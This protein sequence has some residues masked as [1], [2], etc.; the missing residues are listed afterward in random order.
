MPKVIAHIDLNAFFVR[1]EEIRNPRLENKPVAVGGNGRAGIVSTCSYEARKRGVH[2][3]MPTFKAKEVCPELIVINGHYRD[4]EVYSNEFINYIKQYTSKV[5]QV[6]IDECFADFTDQIKKISDPIKYFKDIQNGLFK[7]TGLKCSIGI[8]TTKFLAK[9]A[10]DIKK[11][12]GLTVIRL[13]D[14]EKILFNLPVDTYFGIGRKTAPRLHE[15]G[16]NTIGDLYYGLKDENSK[17]FKF[18][19]HFSQDLINNL[20]GKSSNI[21]EEMVYDPQS[22][23]TRSTLPFDIST[24]EGLK[25]YLIKVFEENFSRFEKLKK[26]AGGVTISYRYTDFK[27]QTCAKKLDNPTDDKN[28]LLREVLE[29]FEQTYNK[30]SVRQ[31]GVIFY[32]LSNRYETSIQMSIFDY[33]YYSERDKTKDIIDDLNKKIEGDDGKLFI[34]SDLLKRK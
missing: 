31:I 20:E 6:S 26:L 12:M 22:I 9:M 7:K 32:N 1:C 21:V 19:G 27:T 15:I 17:V 4:Y 28:I 33:E 8:S 11:P 29:Q 30:K 10:S 16:I 5:E 3:G 18:F 14:V 25:P 13:K 2:S 34:A 23:S 24:F